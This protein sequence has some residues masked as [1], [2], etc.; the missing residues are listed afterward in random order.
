MNRRA[1]VVPLVV[2]A[3]V[4]TAFASST[5][6]SAS[7]GAGP[8]I[9]PQIGELPAAAAAIMSK[10]EFETARW[11][12]SV[13]EAE[14]G[15]VVLADRAGEF[16]FTASTAKNF[17][18][19]TAYATLGTDATLTTPV[20]A[21]AEPA[22]GVLAGNLVLVASGDL[23]M[24]GRGAMSGRVDHAFTA[25]T[26]DHVYGDIAPN[27]A[28]VPDDPLAGLDDLAR[29]VAAS[30]VTEIA[31]DVVIDTRLWNTFDGQEG[32]APSIYV[33]DNILDI[34][35]TSTGIG[36]P[37]VLDLRPETQ[38]VTV[39]STVTTTDAGTPTSLTVTADPG[40]PTSVTVSGTI[41]AGASQLAIHRVPDAASWAR[42]LFVEALGRAGVTVTSP[43]VGPNDQTGLPPTGSYPAEDRVA[44]LTSPPLEAFG[45]MILETSYNT[46]AN[47]LMCLLAAHGGSPDCLDGLAAVHS[48]LDRAG[49]ASDDVV[50][51]DGQGADP[52]STTSEQMVA[53]LRW[54]R[55]QPWGVEF[56]AD[57]PVLGVSGTLASTGQDGPAAGEVAAK[58]GT[59]VDVDPT[60]GRVYYKVE[61]LAGYL[62]TE[63]GERLVF[64]L[65]MS[66]ATYPDVPTGLHDANEDVAAVAAAFQQAL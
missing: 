2:S 61:S 38:A 21:T 53:W 37:A 18:V 50:L 29:Q 54:A 47:A 55:T 63:R 20:Y 32:P 59:S 44:S 43:A 40:D 66:G 35:V 5:E 17:T 52:A 41:A 56:A 11:L 30:G 6:S 57:L 15:R 64:S 31:G 27:A 28:L 9:R 8:S 7:P 39:A 3:V 49:I 33:N 12:Y 14:T 4:L 24:G 45:R 36:Q 22:G 34:T 10:P 62:T 51:F 65:S 25:G 13:A 19:G 26:I 16:V 23:A 60:T 48:Q 58:T 46:G 42:T 1:A